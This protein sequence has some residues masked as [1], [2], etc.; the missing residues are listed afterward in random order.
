VACLPSPR[1]T[2][3][4]RSRMSWLQRRPWLRRRRAEYVS[5]TFGGLLPRARSS[6]PSSTVGSTWSTYPLVRQASRGAR[7][8]LLK[9]SRCLTYLARVP[10]AATGL[11]DEGIPLVSVM[12]E[13][14]RSERTLICQDLGDK[15]R[16]AHA[17]CTVLWCFYIECINC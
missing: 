11:P 5:L 9:N 4:S 13:Q 7:Q 17:G 10:G 8:P 3:D 15:G 2:I 12:R 16:R 14:D 1:L 6:F